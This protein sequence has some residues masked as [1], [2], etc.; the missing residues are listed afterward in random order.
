MIRRAKKKKE[1]KKVRTKA[2]KTRKKVIGKRESWI[3]ISKNERNR[4]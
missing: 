1:L 4:F 3:L 2:Q